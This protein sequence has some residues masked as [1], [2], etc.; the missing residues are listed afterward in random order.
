MLQCRRFPP[1]SGRHARVVDVVPVSQAI[2]RCNCIFIGS[3]ESDSEKGPHLSGL[4][5]CDLNHDSGAIACN[6]VLTVRTTWSEP[7]FLIH[8]ETCHLAIDNLVPKSVQM[9]QFII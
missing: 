7:W 6:W 9:N 5:T 2:S 4:G 3:T 1:S 8:D